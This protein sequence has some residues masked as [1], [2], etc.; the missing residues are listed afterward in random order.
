MNSQYMNSDFIEVLYSPS[1]CKALL[2]SRTNNICD[3]ISSCSKTDDLGSWVILY[4]FS[5]RMGKT[6]V[7]NFLKY[8]T[9]F[10]SVKCKYSVFVSSKR[11]LK[12]F[13]L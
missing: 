1:E 4:L 12:C 6:I 5:D 2:I 13:M 11:T 7:H 9:N 10:H 3:E 8:S